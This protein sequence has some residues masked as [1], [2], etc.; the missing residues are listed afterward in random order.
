M[1]KDQVILGIELIVKVDTV[2]FLLHCSISQE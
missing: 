1:R 2:L